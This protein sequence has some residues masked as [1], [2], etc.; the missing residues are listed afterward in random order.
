VLTAKFQGRQKAKMSCVRFSRWRSWRLGGKLV[1][2]AIVSDS[3][4]RTTEQRFFTGS[5]LF[6]RQRLLVNKRIT[7]G[8]RAAKVLRRGIAADVAVDT[9]RIDVV[10][11]EHIFFH[12]FV[13]IGQLLLLPQESSADYA[14]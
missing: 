13:S 8:V 2:A 12:A 3:F 7:V 10:S 5:K 1:F 14:D 9:R 6:F 4:N 11:A